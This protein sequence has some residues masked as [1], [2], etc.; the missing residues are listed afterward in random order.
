[1]VK[2]SCKANFVADRASRKRPRQE[3]DHDDDEAGAAL[4]RLTL[5]S[6]KEDLR[7]RRVWPGRERGGS[8]LPA[9]ADFP[10]LMAPS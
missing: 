8:S 1:M 3:V 6:A 2:A 9:S 10:T 5:S 7:F 4:L